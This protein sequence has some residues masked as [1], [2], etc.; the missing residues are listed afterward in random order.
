MSQSYIETF[1]IERI[2][3]DTWTNNLREMQDIYAQ[4]EQLGRSTV[5]SSRINSYRDAIESLMRAD[6]EN[7]R[8]SLSLAELMLH[9]TVEFAQLKTIIKATNTSPERASWDDRLRTLISGTNIPSP[10]SKHSPT[11]DFQFESFV[12]AV[13]ELSGYKVRFAE[14]DVIV[15]TDGYAFGIA[16][17]RPR[18]IRGIEKNVKKAA[19]QIL[20]SGL[21]GIIALDMSFALYPN[22]CINTNDLI[23][24]LIFVQKAANDFVDKYSEKFRKICRDDNVL[25]VLVSL[26]MPVLNYG[27]DDGPQLATA[28]RWTL[29]PYCEANE[30]RL[31]WIFEFARR[32]ELGLLGPRSQSEEP[33]I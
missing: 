8:P 18:S 17:K 27:H 25:G 2:T 30:G 24:G 32:C 3:T 9:T 28:V 20:Q 26:Q 15:Q 13:A 10:E 11:R 21:P 14:P 7:R 5:P 1:N 22:Q 16:A 29:A 19:S 4:F 33:T 31:K 12:A 23:G 6:K